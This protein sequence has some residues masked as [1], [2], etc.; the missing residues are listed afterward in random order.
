[1]KCDEVYLHICD[2]LD[3]NMESPRCR[4]IR[5]HLEDCPDC[6]DYLRTLKLTIAL[7]KAAPVPRL[8]AAQHRKLFKT[9]AEVTTASEASCTGR[10][11]ART[12]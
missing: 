12:R 2:S 4:A 8:P 9:I 7:Y 1:M 11:K 5:K 10:K 6:Q 3:E